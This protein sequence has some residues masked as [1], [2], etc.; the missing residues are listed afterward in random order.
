[1]A[2]RRK[3]E[4]IRDLNVIADLAAQ[5]IE[6][7]FLDEYLHQANPEVYN[8]I[9]KFLVSPFVRFTPFGAWE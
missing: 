2:Q 5:L 8:Y 1:M 4:T 6:K 9:Q 7:P 3:T